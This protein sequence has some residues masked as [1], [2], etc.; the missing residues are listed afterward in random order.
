MDLT[1]GWAF[2]ILQKNESPSAFIGKAVNDTAWPR[3]RLGVWQTAEWPQ[4][5]AIVLR[6]HFTIPDDWA[7]DVSLTMESGSGVYF[8][9]EG[10][11]YLDG[12][13]IHQKSK[14]GMDGFAAKSLQPG[15]THEL[16]VVIASEGTL[17][18]TRGNA[19]LWLW[20]SPPEKINLAGSWQESPDALRWGKSVELP[21]DYDACVLKRTVSVPASFK[22]IEHPQ[23]YLDVD[24]SGKLIGALVNGRF[25]R[26]YHRITAD[27]FQLNVTPW[28]R[29]GEE[30]EI[31]LVRHWDESRGGTVRSVSLN[32]Y[33]EPY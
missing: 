21:G 23:T 17:C 18:G 8:A 2:H 15:S 16:V 19:W 7:G 29:L 12:E 14:S 10:E 3:V 32:I 5:K 26:R 25:V 28:I 4:P 6:R 30:N 13:C 1:D 31:Q 24:A 20:P 33:P 9:G 27:R 22:G 11:I